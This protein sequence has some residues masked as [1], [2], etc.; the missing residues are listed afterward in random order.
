MPEPHATVKEELD[1]ITASLIQHTGTYGV[2]VSRHAITNRNASFCV[3]LHVSVVASS[4][5]NISVE[6]GK[7]MLVIQRCLV[8]C[9]S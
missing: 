8:L 9:I 7:G 2:D 6:V 3:Y 5:P 4:F 1:I